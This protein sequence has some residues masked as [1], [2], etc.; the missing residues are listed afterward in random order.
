M[1]KTKAKTNSSPV[2]KS[3]PEEGTLL[4]WICDFVP[5]P[6]TSTV[7][8]IKMDAADDKHIKK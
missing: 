4:W 5:T 7:D 8:R 3:T 2:L 1:A 6:G